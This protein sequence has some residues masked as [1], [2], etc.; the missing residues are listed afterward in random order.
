MDR[1][2]DAV[3]EESLRES[4]LPDG[5]LRERTATKPKSVA[6]LKEELEQ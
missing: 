1:L 3:V 2:Y 6:A 4:W 5:R